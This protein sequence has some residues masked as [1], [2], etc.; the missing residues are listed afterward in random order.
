MAR[1]PAGKEFQVTYDIKLTVGE[2]VVA[3]TLE[4][5]LAIGR[6]RRPSDVLDLDDLEYIDGEIEVTGVY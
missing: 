4:D 3:Q 5:A 1:K 2:P 6:K